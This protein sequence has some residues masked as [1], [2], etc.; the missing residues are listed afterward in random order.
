MASSEHPKP[1]VWECPG[2]PYLALPSVANYCALRMAYTVL[3]S[4][5]R[6]QM[7]LMHTP[8]PLPE[9]VKMPIFGDRPYFRRYISARQTPQRYMSQLRHGLGDDCH[10]A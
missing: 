3:T 10:R 4:M 2:L 8:L 9:S 1:K 5:C 7:D 6:N